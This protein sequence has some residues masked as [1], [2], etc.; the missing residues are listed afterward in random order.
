MKIMLYTIV[1]MYLFGGTV[2]LYRWLKERR[3]PRCSCVFID[4]KEDNDGR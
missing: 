2:S 1:G 4:H 3:I